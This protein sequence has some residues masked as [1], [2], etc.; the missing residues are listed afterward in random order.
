[1]E[2]VLGTSEHNPHGLD[3]ANNGLLGRFRTIS[4][5]AD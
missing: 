3:R 1:M 5:M 2:L 4:D